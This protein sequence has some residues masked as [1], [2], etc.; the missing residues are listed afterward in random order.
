MGE[1]GAS[2]VSVIWILRPETV[3]GGLDLASERAC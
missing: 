2:T 1:L 3:A